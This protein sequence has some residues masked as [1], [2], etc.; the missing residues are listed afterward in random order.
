MSAFME[1]VEFEQFYIYA[2]VFVWILL[3]SSCYLY[4]AHLSPY[5]F[6]IVSQAGR[7]DWN[8]GFW[9]CRGRS[10]NIDIDL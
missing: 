1:T 9:L 7:G 10:V 6:R 2:Q 3:L 5:F 4:I 8:E